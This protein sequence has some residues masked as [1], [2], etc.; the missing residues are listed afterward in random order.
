MS[1]FKADYYTKEDGS[2]PAKEFLLSQ[3]DKMQAKLFGLIDVL[4]EYGNQLRGPYSEP[5]GDGIFELRAKFGTDIS[6]VLY[7]FYYEGRI[8]LTHGFVK[9]TQKTPRGEIEKAKRY[10][11]DFLERY[12]DK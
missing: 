10:R 8:I 4:E 11:N 6:R 5:L 3:N 7:F 9:K 12:G 1:N 2:K